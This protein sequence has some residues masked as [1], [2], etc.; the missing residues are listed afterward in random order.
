ATALSLERGV[1]P[2]TITQAVPDPACDLDYVPNTAREQPLHVALSNSFGSA[3]QHA[4]LVQARACPSDPPGS[5]SRGGSNVP[6]PPPRI[7][8]P[9]LNHRPRS[10]VTRLPARMRKLALTIAP[11]I[12][13]LLAPPTGANGQPPSPAAPVLA[14]PQATPSPQVTGLNVP[15]GL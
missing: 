9:A 15:A 11:V 4:S 5:S 8:C 1:I 7:R 6:V 12:G 2:P 13:L 3:G 14:S 10:S